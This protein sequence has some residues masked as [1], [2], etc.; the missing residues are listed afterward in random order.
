[1]SKVT[2]KVNSNDAYDEFLTNTGSQN[3]CIGVDD[4]DQSYNIVTG[5]DISA[6]KALS[7]LPSKAISITG[8]ATSNFTTS[9]GELTLDGA[10]GVS[11]ET[12]GTTALTFDSSGNITKI[13]QSSPSDGYFLKWDN[14][15]TKAIWSASSGSNTISDDST[16]NDRPIVFS[17][18]SDNLLDDTGSFFYNPGN[19]RMTV[20]TSGT[21]GPEILLKNTNEDADG[22]VLRFTKDSV[23]PAISDELGKIDFYGDDSAGNSQSFAS[24]IATTLGVTSDS[25]RGKLNF[26]VATGTDGTEQSIMTI[27]GSTTN[28]ISSTV[29]VVGNLTCSSLTS[30]EHIV[31]SD[32]KLK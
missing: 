29:A 24:I 27:E 23:S 22:G 15:N 31:T 8:A 20:E 7:I 25:E 28:A 2:R 30:N 18:N 21:T 5:T 6:N 26:K 12:G 4:T 9:S 14:S 16:S 3:W 17:D 11:L 1:M 10:G 19:S 32:R 13:G